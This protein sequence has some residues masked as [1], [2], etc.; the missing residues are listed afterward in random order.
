[1]DRFLQHN[2]DRTG[3]NYQRPLPGLGEP[4]SEIEAE[5]RMRGLIRAFDEKFGQGGGPSGS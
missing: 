1:M 5:K 2:S 3:Q 4:Q